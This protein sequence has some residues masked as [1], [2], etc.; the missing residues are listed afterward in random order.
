M[1]VF[2][3][4]RERERE[5]FYEHFFAHGRLDETTFRYAHAE[6]PTQVVVICDPTPYR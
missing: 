1:C 5:M 6:I 3:R 4:E 2:V